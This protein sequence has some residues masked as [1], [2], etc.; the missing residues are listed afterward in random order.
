MTVRS[1]ASPSIKRC[2]RKRRLIVDTDLGLDDLV[3]LAILRIQQ[4]MHQS[5]HD[6]GNEKL[7]SFHL[8]GVTVTPGVSDATERNATLLRRL[9]PPNTPVYV[10]SVG[11][12]DAYDTRKPAWWT[13]TSNRVSSFLS[14]LPPVPIEPQCGDITAEQFIAKHVDDPDVDFLCMAP[15]STVARALRARSE[16]SEKCDSA[17]FYIMGGIRSDSRVTKRGESTAPDLIGQ[18]KQSSPSAE[19][20]DDERDLFGEFNFG[21]DIDAARTVLSAISARIVPLEA[22]TFVPNSIRRPHGEPGFELS[23]ILSGSENCSGKHTPESTAN[24]LGIAR[25]NL[26]RLLQEASAAEIQWDS[27]FAAVYCNAFGTAFVGDCAK[28]SALTQIYAGELTLS[29]VGA[30][31]FPGCWNLR[32]PAGFQARNNGDNPRM[33]FIYPSFTEKDELKFFKYLSHLLN[34]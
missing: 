7:T 30:M 26:L 19:A 32:E 31:N 27:I 33:H 13:R 5:Q 1:A 24:E 15:L 25:N 10:S 22:C 4:C 3:A 9:L 16:G 21:I 18:T 6:A 17:S 8:H 23:S 29:N 12:N 14:S 34:M 28:S 2:T 11:R 20:T